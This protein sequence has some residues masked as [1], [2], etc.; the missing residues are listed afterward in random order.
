M[1]FFLDESVRKDFFGLGCLC[2]KIEEFDTILKAAEE[3]KARLKLEPYHRLKYTLGNNDSIEKAQ[4]LQLEKLFGKNWKY[5]FREAIA[6]FISSLNLR[7]VATLHQDYR[8]YKTKKSDSLDFYLS[9]L[10]A[11]SCDVICWVVKEEKENKNNIIII[12]KPPQKNIIVNEALINM[13]YSMSL[14]PKLKRFGFIDSIFIS[15]DK[16]SIFLQLADFYIGVL[17]EYLRFSEKPSKKNK[18]AVKLLRKI[19]NSLY[20]LHMGDKT[21]GIKVFHIPKLLRSFKALLEITVT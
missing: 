5:K 3:F 17:V 1:F 12:D 11:L 14:Y 19:K 21:Y 15:N 16:H 7:F 6:N 10:N 8:T 18:H 9:A 20:P 13:A 4:M 2:V